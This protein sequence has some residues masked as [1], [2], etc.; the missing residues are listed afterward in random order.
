MWRGFLRGVHSGSLERSR[1]G[2]WPRWRSRRYW[3]GFGLIRGRRHWLR[4]PLNWACSGGL[5]RLLLFLLLSQGRLGGVRFRGGRTLGRRW[6]TWGPQVLALLLLQVFTVAR[7]GFGGL[8]DVIRE[9]LLLCSWI[10]VVVQVVGGTSVLQLLRLLDSDWRGDGVLLLLLQHSRRRLLNDVVDEMW[11][12][13]L[14][15][16]WRSS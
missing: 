7:G 16:L 1:D 8:R 10:L 6:P 11:L 15:L 4:Y 14:L 5:R 13:L 2:D 3:L 12:L 9:L